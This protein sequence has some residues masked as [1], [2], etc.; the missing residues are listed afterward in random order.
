M[1][2]LCDL[3]EQVAAASDLVVLPEMAVTGYLFDS[4]AE[5]RVVAEAP[6]GPTFQ[7]LAPI[8]RAQQAWLVCGFP[9]RDGERLFNSA[10]VIGPDG[11]LRF[12][13]RKTLLFDADTSWALPG[14]SGYLAFEVCGYRV[15]V[16]IC[17]DLNDDRFVAWCTRESIDVLALPT[18]WL[19]QGEDVWSYWAWRMGPIRRTWL[20]AA[21]TWGEEGPIRFSGR[22]LAMRDWR[23]HAAL[24]VE[25]NGGVSVL[26]P[27]E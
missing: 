27:S 19:D 11:G 21:N 17:M 20:L 8:A 15:A 14:D 26:L 4:P 18:N 3:T 1:R 10:M 24:E 6:D 13:Y 23:V 25:G 5:A 2:A 7:A 9:E 16:G 12:C 22:S